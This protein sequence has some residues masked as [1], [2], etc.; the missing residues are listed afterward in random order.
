MRPV[1]REGGKPSLIWMAMTYDGVVIDG[2]M[3]VSMLL[4]VVVKSDACKGSR[5][6]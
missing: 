4:R 5:R 1:V 2:S 3:V 6:C